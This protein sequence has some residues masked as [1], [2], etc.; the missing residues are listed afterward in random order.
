MPDVHVIINSCKQKILAT[1]LILDLKFSINTW[2]EFLKQ[3]D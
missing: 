2:H 1:T 3:G